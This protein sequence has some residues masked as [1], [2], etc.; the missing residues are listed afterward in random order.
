MFGIAIHTSLPAAVSPLRTGP[1]VAPLNPVAMSSETQALLT[2]TLDHG[3]HTPLTEGGR[4]T[5]QIPLREPAVPVEEAGQRIALNL[6]AAQP[7]VAYLLRHVSS[8]NLPLPQ[9]AEATATASPPRADAGERVSE[10]DRPT[11][12]AVPESQRPTPSPGFPAL[13]SSELAQLLMYMSYLLMEYGNQERENSAEMTTIRRETQIAANEQ[14]IAAAETAVYAAA[15]GLA[16]T[17]ALGVVGTK[18]T[19]EGTDMQTKNVIKNQVPGNESSVAAATA[20]KATKRGALPTIEQRPARDIHGVAQPQPANGGQVAADLQADADAST[21]AMRAVVTANPAQPIADS[22]NAASNIVGALAQR[23]FAQGALLNMLA[24]AAGG[25]GSAAWQPQKSAQE[26]A[27]ARL[28]T[29]S[30]VDA[31][32]AANMN[33]Q[34]RITMEMALAFF[35]MAQSLLSQKS[36]TADHITRHI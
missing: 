13:A 19:F 28:N 11:V 4:T 12:K 9:L 10:S 3:A 8:E 26:A 2:S 29:D 7:L 6:S 34:K 18:K 20:A 14:K 27:E 32:V 21:P 30:Q 36:N 31:E 23:M 25:L 5:A 22:A 33:E 15:T 24:G 16:L 17:A 35:Q 1:A